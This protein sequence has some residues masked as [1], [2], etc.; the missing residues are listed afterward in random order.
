MLAA[1]SALAQIAPAASAQTSAPSP[2]AALASSREVPAE[3]AATA[4]SGVAEPVIR[5]TVI[6]SKGSHIEELR[7][8]G[9]LQSVIVTP[10][11]AA[12]AYE[13]ITNSD[14]RDLPQEGKTNSRGA[15]GKR[16][17]S[18]LRF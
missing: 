16:V 8:R 17:W 13:V 1:F 12:P 11:G 14:G 4:A 6:D 2:T 15:A 5:R 7:V 3:A 9:Q 18:V 10:K